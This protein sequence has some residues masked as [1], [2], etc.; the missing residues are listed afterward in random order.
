M[1]CIKDACVCQSQLSCGAALSL[2]R[3]MPLQHNLSFGCGDVSAG[4]RRVGALFKIQVESFLCVWFSLDEQPTFHQTFESN[5]VNHYGHLVSSITMTADK[6]LLKIRQTFSQCHHHSV[7][8][9]SFSIWSELLSC[10]TSGSPVQPCEL[11]LRMKM[12]LGT[13]GPET[14]YTVPLHS[15]WFYNISV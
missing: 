12:L 3:L 14:S 2:S 5:S 10:F 6:D 15:L 9:F 8:G 1:L 4:K 7:E 11:R 13:L